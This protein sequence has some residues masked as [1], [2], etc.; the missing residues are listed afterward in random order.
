MEE[1]RPPGDAR[2]AAQ[3]AEAARLGGGWVYEIDG[4]QV[5][6]P[7][8]RVPASAITGAWQIG[9]DGEV[10]GAFKPNPNYRPPTN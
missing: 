10:I 7:D 8:G 9:A 6:D 5:D 3:R 1:R 4:A 2:F